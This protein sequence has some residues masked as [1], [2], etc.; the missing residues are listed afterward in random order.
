L[1]D[2]QFCHLKQYLGGYM[3]IG[4]RYFAFTKAVNRNLVI[5]PQPP[6]ITPTLT[7]AEL[8]QA[9]QAQ[10]YKISGIPNKLDYI[11]GYQRNIEASIQAQEQFSPGPLSYIGSFF[12]AIIKPFALLGAVIM[13]IGADLFYRA[14]LDIG[15]GI[16]GLFRSKPTVENTDDYMN[17]NQ[18]NFTEKRLTR[19]EAL[20]QYTG[21]APTTPGYTPS[22]TRTSIDSTT[23]NAQTP[24]V[25]VSVLQTPTTPI[26][27][28]PPPL[29]SSGYVDLK[30]T[31]GSKEQPHPSITHQQQ[32]QQTPPKVQQIDEATMLAES[33]RTQNEEVSRKTSLTEAPTEAIKPVKPK[34]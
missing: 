16:A 32:A 24:D 14:P 4:D 1:N 28:A 18:F 7:E 5:L 13:D 21:V 33:L 9:F 25:P 30:A 19:E 29:F 20:Q 22:A 23:V 3:A 15:N 10:R 31:T 2:Y 26:P 34:K 6:A 12:K 11:E 27:D 8:T 17:I